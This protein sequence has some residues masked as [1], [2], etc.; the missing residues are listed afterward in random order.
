MPPNQ[1]LSFPICK[2]GLNVIPTLLQPL[3]LPWSN[4]WKPPSLASDTFNIPMASTIIKIISIFWAPTAFLG[5]VLTPLQ[6]CEVNAV[7]MPISQMRK[8]ARRGGVT[9]P[10]HTACTEQSWD[11]NPYDLGA[12]PLITV[13]HGPWEEAVVLK[14]LKLNTVPIKHGIKGREHCL[15]PLAMATIKKQ[16]VVLARE[17][18]TH[19]WCWWEYNM[20]QTRWRRAWRFLQK[21]NIESPYDPAIPLLHRHPKEMKAGFQRSVCTPMLIAVHNSPKVEAAPL[22]IDR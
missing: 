4:S 22:S 19:G 5:S 13:L 12:T 1:L 10:S 8:Q 9:C 21:L 16:K 17:I 14:F 15:T 2:N 20:V 3:G 18:G 11:L 7:T 6:A